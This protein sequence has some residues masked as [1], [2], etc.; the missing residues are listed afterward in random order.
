M[1]YFELK[2]KLNASMN[3]K[4][5]TYHMGINIDTHCHHVLGINPHKCHCSCMDWVNK[6]RFPRNVIQRIRHSIDIRSPP[7]MFPY[8]FLCVIVCVRVIIPIEILSKQQ[9]DNKNGKHI[10]ISLL[11]IL[12]LRLLMVLE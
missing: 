7:S 8:D 6:R 10:L 1:K 4:Q 2:N 12:K 9:I 3:K 5:S 11:S